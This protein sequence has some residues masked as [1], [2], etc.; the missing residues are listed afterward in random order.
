[1]AFLLNPRVL[2]CLALAGFLS[3]THFA[4]YRHGKGVV[5]VEWDKSIAA[6]NKEARQ[7]EQRRQ[8]TVDAAVVAQTRR[9]SVVLADSGR[10]AAAL[11]GLRD[12][13]AARD[14]AEESASAATERAA[15]LGK[16]LVSCGAAYQELG[17]VADGHVNDIRTLLESWPK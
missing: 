9:K 17:R 1:M 6:A 15:T 10:A 14:V 16:L 5:H 12:A 11:D 4:A 3:F 7:I 2:I 8:G 13:I